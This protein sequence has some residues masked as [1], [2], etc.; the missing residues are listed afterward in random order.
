MSD[1][2]F[3][4]RCLKPNGT[5]DCIRYGHTATEYD[6]PGKETVVDITDSFDHSAGQGRSLVSRGTVEMPPRYFFTAGLGRHDETRLRKYQQ[7]RISLR[8]QTMEREAE[9]ERRTGR[10][11]K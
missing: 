4:K 6:G 3:R 5:F 9:S 11:P 1:I 10:R 8:E 7:G 2:D